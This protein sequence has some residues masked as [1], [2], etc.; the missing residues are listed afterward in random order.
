M[1]NCCPVSVSAYP[2]FAVFL[3][4]GSVLV[5]RAQAQTAPDPSTVYPQIVRLSYVEG[6]VRIARGKAAEK[7]DKKA[8]QSPG[9]V[10]GWE[11]AA[12]GLP[13]EAGYSL[14]T[15]DGRAEI[16]LENASTLELAPNSVL[17]LDALESQNSVTYTEASLL[18]GSLVVNSRSQAGDRIHLKS[19][20]DHLTIG[21]PGWG[22][23]RVDSYLDAI[24]ITRLAGIQ[25]AKARGAVSTPLDQTVAFSHGRRILAPTPPD[26]DALVAWDNWTLGRIHERET[27]LDATMK[28]A[29]LAEPLPGLDQLAGKGTFFSC[30]EYGTCWEPSAGWDGK[31]QADVTTTD[32]AAEALQRWTVSVKDV[33]NPGAAPPAAGI[34]NP[35]GRPTPVD[36]YLSS[37]PGATFYTEDYTFPC[38]A[39]SVRQL[40]AV[41]PVTRKE[42]LV[43]S[44]FDTALMDPYMMAFPHRNTLPPP[45]AYYTQYI[46]Y[47]SYWQGGPWDWTVCHSGTWIRWN[48]RYVWVAGV[49]RHYH[50]PVYWVRNGH[51][52][53]YVP[54]HPRDVAGKPPVNLKEGLFQVNGKHSAVMHVDF[55]EAKGL[56]LLAEPP[57]EFRNTQ[58]AMLKAVAM[59]K[60][61]AHSAWGA[62][63]SESVAARNGQLVTPIARGTGAVNQAAA[64]KSFTDAHRDGMVPAHHEGVPINFD[65]KTQSFSVTREISAEGGHGTTVS[66]RIGG[67]QAFGPTGAGGWSSA[68]GGNNNA[69]GT[70]ASGS[71]P[72]HGF[73]SNNGGGS[74]AGGS[75]SVHGFSGPSGGSSNAGSGASHGGGNTNAGGGGYSGGGGGAS[76]SSG[77]GY[78]GGGGSS[79]GGGASSAGASSGG[80]S[81]HK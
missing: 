48:H 28:Q 44:E 29:G 50:C 49:H 19:P 67:G 3:V 73:S 45:A 25:P 57:K 36:N 9:P 14:V 10:T 43:A 18:S 17:T 31:R 38:Q 63:Q 78:S 30:G 58:L 46:G 66:T 77:G 41:D 39:Y 76:H 42:K 26:A 60:A 5:P 22:V 68:H 65:R 64:A 20:T 55:E 2:L 40:I 23:W 16:E 11:Q 21:Y 4:A 24:A 59:P 1:R 12:M 7:T 8:E 53:G 32:P 35:A 6:D 62:R 70:Q 74:N 33:A 52:E 69:G 71:A 80:G 34:P 47:A 75:S 61:E 81:S 56:K 72:G 15:G 37:H 51:H 13:L 79:G 27:T 54:I